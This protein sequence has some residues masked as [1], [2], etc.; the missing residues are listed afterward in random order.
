MGRRVALKVLPLAAAM[1]PQALKRFQLEAR[2]A[3]LLQHPHIVPVHDV[4]TV[5]EVPYFAMKFMALV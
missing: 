3:G 2:V 1:D 5:D 4:G